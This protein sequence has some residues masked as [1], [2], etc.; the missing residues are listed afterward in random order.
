MSSTENRTGIRNSPGSIIT[1]IITK[2]QHGRKSIVLS[3]KDQC[4]NL[5]S[6]SYWLCVLS[7]PCHLSL[8]ACPYREADLTEEESRQ[9]HETL[10]VQQPSP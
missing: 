1:I 10:K 3:H 6:V 7:K 4:L 2:Q 9:T 5:S 8:V